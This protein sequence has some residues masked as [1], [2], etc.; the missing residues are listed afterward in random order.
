[1]HFKQQQMKKLTTL[2]LF[3]ALLMAGCTKHFEG[4]NTNPNSP[5][6]VTNPGL[7]LP[8]VIRSSV[9][10]ELYSSYARGS[11]VAN[12][13]ASDFA[14]NFSNWSRNDAD[15]YFLWGYYNH[16]R[17]LNDLINLA[18]A[19]GLSNYKGIALVLRAWLFQSLTDIYGP[20][21]FREA[22][23]AKFQNISTPK[24]EKQED[25]YPGLLADLDEA[26]TLLG[27]S[28]ETVIGDI[29]YSGATDKWKKFSTALMLR[30]LMRESGR[31]D[32]SAQMKSIVGNASK[33]P[34][35]TSYQDQAALTYLEDRLDNYSPFYNSGN[36]ETDTKITKQLLGFFDDMNDP[37]IP[38]Y[39]LPTPESAA[40]DANGNRPPSSQFEYNGE[41][42][43]NGQFLNANGSSA[44]G[45]LWMSSQ[46]SPALASK[47]AAQGI[48]ISYSE[49][50]FILAEAAQKGLI[51]GGTS[52]AETYYLNGIKDQFAYWASRIPG[53]F[54]SSYLE[55]T[56]AEVI[57]PDSYYTQASV[58]Y[59]GPDQE[60][61]EKIWKQKW[62]SLY[63][64][65]FEAWSEQ[66][67]TNY[68]AIPIGPVGP[69]YI[70]SRMLYPA[71][72]TRINVTNYNE[73]VSWLGADDLQSHV[74]WDVN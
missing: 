45:M 35:F 26:N 7:L 70:P 55:L 49:V 72:E 8:N 68:P 74:W 59:T 44:F 36:G 23:N 71:D 19:Q 66:R 18:D 50:Q 10:S 20:I 61:L 69:G 1:M 63:M 29:L 60:K 62:I 65:G 51:D 6:A 13:L 24:Y 38:V 5:D 15:G 47:T 33:Y 42:N 56:P 64:V 46:Y 22:A 32:V 14:S 9:N 52:A 34:M 73:A 17:D 11:I 25:V 30:I 37:R 28:S 67:R 3:A 53:T 2:I 16:I 12:L 58:A 21:P 4:I 39:A 40:A 31:V 41:L 57:P 43:G 54:A 27:T 48:I